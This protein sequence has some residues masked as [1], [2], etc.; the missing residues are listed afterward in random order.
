MTVGTKIPITSEVVA[1]RRADYFLVLPW[2]FRNEFIKREKEWLDKGG[3]FVFPLPQFEV[4]E[5]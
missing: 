4:Y 1:R 5:N 3:K 2:H